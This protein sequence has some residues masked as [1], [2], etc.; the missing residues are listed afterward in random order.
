MATALRT[1]HQQAVERHAYPYQPYL[2]QVAH[3]DGH[4]SAPH[5]AFQQRGGGE[6]E[7]LDQVV[8]LVLVVMQAG[9]RPACVGCGQSPTVKDREAVELVD[10]P[11]AGRQRRLFWHKVRWLC[12]NDNCDMMIWTWADPRIWAPRQR[13][14]NRA[15]RWVTFQLGA[16]ARRCRRSPATWLA[17]HTVNDAVIA[18]GEALTDDDTHGIG[19]FCAIGG[20]RRALATPWEPCAPPT[21]RVASRRRV[22]GSRPERGM[23]HGREVA[24]RA[25]P[26]RRSSSSPSLRAGRTMFGVGCPF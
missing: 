18:S 8:V 17:W 26:T 5:R 7:R 1:R 3:G 23:S 11:Y 9:P 20:G 4:A 25:T 22:R 16:K 13:L 15:A 2:R 10:L 24:Y 21:Y 19:T 12:S 6:A 14:M